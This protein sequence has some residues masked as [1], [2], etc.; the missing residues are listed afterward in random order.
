MVCDCFASMFITM[1]D[2]MPEIVL[3]HPGQSV[4][5]LKRALED[6]ARDPSA[7]PDVAD[8]D[9]PVERKRRKVAS[10]KVVHNNSEVSSAR[11]ENGSDDQEGK[12]GDTSAVLPYEIEVKNDYDG[13]F[14]RVVRNCIEM[15]L[16]EGL[17]L[18]HSRFIITSG[19]WRMYDYRWTE[20]KDDPQLL[21]IDFYSVAR[22][23]MMSID[24]DLTEVL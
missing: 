24:D 15:K 5:L 12:E 23:G 21:N 18:K 17:P 9:S 3:A 4:S 10:D 11:D 19:P 7:L 2:E 14:E 16:E 20:P 6:V 13:I 1:D 8:D 22:H